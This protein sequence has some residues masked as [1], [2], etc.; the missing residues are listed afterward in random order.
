[1]NP[2]FS[3]AA[4]A[5]HWSVSRRTLQ[6]WRQLGT[7]PGFIRLHRRI[8]YSHTEVE[9][10]EAAN[11]VVAVGAASTMPDRRRGNALKGDA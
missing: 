6:R 2:H 7:G 9:A 11:N 10:F 5:K 4:L 8:V 1:M 3:E